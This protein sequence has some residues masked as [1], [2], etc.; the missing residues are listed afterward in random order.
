MTNRLFLLFIVI[1]FAACMNAP[2]QAAAKK[3]NKTYLK[4]VEA[5]TQRTLAGRP[6]SPPETGQYF[7]V[8]WQAST[9]PETFFWRGDNG[10]LSCKMLRVHKII[11]S[12]TTPKGM[13]HRTEFVTGDQIHKGDTLQLSPVTGGRFPI[14][15]EIP[16]TAKNSL[17]FKTGGSNW[18]SFPVKKIGKKADISM[19]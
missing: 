19:P 11:P 18:L 7:I 1:S 13:D 17:F 3:K 8:V 6:G 16:A 2:A 5:Y 4:L 9:Y 10:W 14:P 15:T 12:H